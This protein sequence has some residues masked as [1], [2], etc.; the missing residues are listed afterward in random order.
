[1][2]PCKINITGSGYHKFNVEIRR[3][4][5][6]SDTKWNDDWY[7]Y[8]WKQYKHITTSLKI[9]IINT[10]VHL[11][12]IHIPIWESDKENIRLNINH[13]NMIQVFIFDFW[14]NLRYKYSNKKLYFVWGKL[15]MKIWH[16]IHQLSRSWTKFWSHLN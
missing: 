5:Q 8:T 10:Y 6:D 16:E 11:S 15:R 7:L 3:I 9:V 1:M 14:R 13:E 4:K 2:K 12:V